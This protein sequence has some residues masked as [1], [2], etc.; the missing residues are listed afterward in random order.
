MKPGGRRWRAALTFA[1]KSASIN[2]IGMI[3]KMIAS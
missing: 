3:A 2:A 1:S